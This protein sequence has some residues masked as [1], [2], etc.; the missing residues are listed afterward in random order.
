MTLALTSFPFLDR[1]N[2]A[3]ME[4]VLASFRI[5]SDEEVRA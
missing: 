1:E 4:Q 3:L 2:S 5:L